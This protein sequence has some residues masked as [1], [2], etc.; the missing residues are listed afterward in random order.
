MH[1]KRQYPYTGNVMRERG[2]KMKKWF[3]ILVLVLLAG[4]SNDE[5]PEEQKNFEEALKVETVAEVEPYT[6]AVEAIN[7]EDWRL[8]KKYLQ[9]T[10]Q[11]FPDSNEAIAVNVLLAYHSLA[12]LTSHADVMKQLTNGLAH[13]SNLI[14]DE[15]IKTLKNYSN[16]SAVT[17]EETKADFM[18]YVEAF[19][20][21][22]DDTKGLSTYF[23]KFA[24]TTADFKRV[25][26]FSFFEDVGVVV[27]N[28]YEI[29]KFIEENS[30]EVMIAALIGLS[31]KYD[32]NHYELLRFLYQSGAFIFSENEQMANQLF[33]LVFKITENDP[34]NE[35]R[36][37][38]EEL[39]D[40]SG[41][42]Y[43]DDTSDVSTLS[44][45]EEVVTFSDEETDSALRKI[46]NGFAEDFARAINGQ[47]PSLISSYFATNSEGEMVV[48]GWMEN[49]INTA[50]FVELLESNVNQI[51]VQED[52][53]YLVYEH[54][55]AKEDD[56]DV[57]Y[58]VTY[59]F[60]QSE[61][62]ILVI[63]EIEY[64]GYLF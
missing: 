36:I 34:Y 2:N 44:T 31:S 24:F 28:E 56:T 57:G 4:C 29:E 54:R 51:E 13:Q 3:S 60:V 39:M 38:T 41:Q 11:D 17:I 43:M 6:K 47:D 26:D 22:F 53:D 20:T 58:D 35:Y 12:V 52:G 55:I 42:Q 10:L 30:R 37:L 62:G 45:N 64:E 63:E 48:Q 23:N 16:Q 49:L 7:R 8:A 32:G 50:T 40:E 59:K 9:L 46:V 33:D 25:S 15:E 1:Q 14:D 5:K 21:H 27:P 19:L 61:T 18:N